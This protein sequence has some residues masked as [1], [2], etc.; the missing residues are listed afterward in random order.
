MDLQSKLIAECPIESCTWTLD[1]SAPTGKEERFFDSA[2]ELFAEY[3]KVVDDLIRAHLET[4]TLLEWVQEVTR[5]RGE[6]E[7]ARRDA[8]DTQA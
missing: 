7:E 4:H 3:A 6:L 2:A 5:L 1:T 8:P